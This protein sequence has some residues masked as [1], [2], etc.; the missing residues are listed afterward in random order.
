VS[1]FRPSVRVAGPDGREWEIY[2]YRLQL[3]D[4]GTPDPTPFELGGT[5][6]GQ[7]ASSML[8]GL[9]YVLLWVPRLLVR[10]FVDLPMAG[11]R[12]LR[13][14][15]WIIEAISWAPFPLSYKWSTTGDVR[16]QVLA[17]VEIALAQGVTPHPRNARLLELR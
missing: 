11:V 8:D 1:I 3:P 15:E 14:D 6:Q 13:K 10:V 4:R 12:A 5:A 7:A 17:L 2:S 9:A 16:G